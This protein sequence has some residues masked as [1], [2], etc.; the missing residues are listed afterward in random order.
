MRWIAA[1][2]VAAL[3]AACGGGEAP[4][5]ATSGTSNP[6]I[7][8]PTAGA[9]NNPNTP[10]APVDPAAAEATVSGTVTGFASTVAVDGVDYTGR[11]DVTVALD[12]DPRAETAATMADVKLGQQVEV[13]LDATGLATKLFVR[14]A[15]IGPVESI[16][17]NG[18]S[19]KVLGQTI[20]VVT[21]GDARTVFEGVDDLS[22]LKVGD[23]TEVHGT[24]DATQNVVATRVEVKP[25]AGVIK[26]RAGGIA[27]MV[28]TA[29]ANKKTFKLGDLTI[30]FTK[31]VVMPDGAKIENDVFVQVFSD[32]LPAAGT[33]VAKAVRVV[34]MPTLEG[35]RLHIGGLVTEAVKEK[36]FKVN[37]LT[38]DATDAEIKGG[39]KPTLDDIKLLALVR[40]EGTLTVPATG[41]V[42]KAT[43]IWVIPA[44]EQRRVILT[45]QV[46]GFTKL[47]DPFTVRGVPVKV[48]SATTYKGGK[49]D[50]LKNSAFV[51]I[52]G[53]ID[54]TNVKADE[55]RFDTPPRGMEIKLFGV[56]SEFKAADG[57]FK[58][59][60]ISMKLAPN[61][62]FEGG[63]KADF[64]NDDVVEVKGAFD[65]TVFL[66][67]KVEFKSGVI[68]PSIYLEGAITN[69]SATGF[70]LNGATIKTDAT[71]VI[72]NGPLANN[73]R[74]EVRAQLV[75]ADVVAREVEVQVPSATARLMGPISDVKAADKTFVVRGQLVTWSA[76]TVFKG[77]A[78]TD[79]S[80]GD[81]VKVE[82]TLAAGKVNATTVSF[83]MH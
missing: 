41:P 48:D 59:L 22:K 61:A 64:S 29:D 14:A 66:V 34:K 83:L 15:A 9:P 31:A 74:V 36:K 6:A 8:P 30:D 33:L 3:M 75:G 23:W 45:G 67:S 57:T 42:L 7:T 70:T 71:T 81:W 60:G 25:A 26:V 69:V 19:F 63:A 79:L 35:R 24:L 27:K 4:G 11:A 39:Q 72:K 21:T 38:V 47:A 54:G 51:T 50:D 62:V 78:A 56:V 80:N 20:K 58:L 12:I 10:A 55:V 28:N 17:L 32:Q 46:S 49:V 13:A 76:T 53:R 68:T 2:A 52:V 82:A 37:G 16:D 43:R 65:G 77:G 44:S 18:A 1:M 73:Q 5:N 40:V